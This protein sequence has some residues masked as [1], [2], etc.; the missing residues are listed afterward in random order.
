MFKLEISQYHSKACENFQL[1]LVASGN[2]VGP[3]SFRIWRLG[4]SQVLDLQ[5]MSSGRVGGRVLPPPRPACWSM[6][7]RSGPAS[8]TLVLSSPWASCSA[9][10]GL[11]WFTCKRS[12]CPLSWLIGSKGAQAKSKVFGSRFLA[13]SCAWEVLLGHVAGQGAGIWGETVAYQLGPS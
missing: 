12:S 10:I 13:A 7:Q 2:C 9:F 6:S 11:R 4:S 8:C 1:A 3:H 5:E